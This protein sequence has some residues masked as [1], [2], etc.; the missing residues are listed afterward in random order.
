MT[1]ISNKMHSGELSW[2]EL[3]ALEARRRSVLKKTDLPMYLLLTCWNGTVWQILWKDPLVY[4]V[5]TMYLTIRVYSYVGNTP[6][7]VSH[8]DAG[9]VAIIGAFLSFFLVYFV[10]TCL[11]RFHHLYNLSMSVEG[12][13]FDCAAITR[14]VFPTKNAMRLVR[15]LNAMHAAAYTGLS[16]VYNF[17]NFFVELNKL[18]HFLTEEELARM[19]AIDMD[20]GGEAYRELTTWCIADVEK[21]HKEGLIDSHTAFQLRELII[22]CLGSLGGT[23]SVVSLRISVA[24]LRCIGILTPL[25]YFVSPQ[26]LYD[27]D[28]QPVSFFYVHFIC[29]LMAVYLPLFS[30][31]AGF[32]AGTGDEHHW[33]L[34]LIEGLLV[35]IE[36]IFLLG[37]RIIAVKLSDPYGNDTE[38]LSVISYVN[39]AWMSSV[40]M[41]NSDLPEPANE[42]VE[43]ELRLG[44]QNY[45]EAWGW[46]SPKKR[47]ETFH[48]DEY[49]SSCS[50]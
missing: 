1:T 19:K 24:F 18:N 4:V 3:Q 46:V 43:N 6:D 8:I 34:D 37:L 26:A 25:Q 47:Q 39:F 14:A 20:K 28:D 12:R 50:F 11:Q 16:S 17:D 36:T 48:E 31:S 40:R 44:T 13:I 22:R 49:G 2:K 27:F 23:F 32:H 41:I 15:Y 10:N 29:V 42:E 45:G 33:S 35:A 21:V 30:I 38:D 9:S 5:M 7:F